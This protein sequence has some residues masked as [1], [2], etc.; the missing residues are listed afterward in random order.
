[1]AVCRAVRGVAGYLGSGVVGRRARS[2]M[3]SA[4]SCN[5]LKM[6]FRRRGE[7]VQIEET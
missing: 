5:S 7:E 1:M 6:F 2:Q 3:Q 4:G